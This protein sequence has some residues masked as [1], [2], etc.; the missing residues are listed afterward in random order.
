MATLDD[1]QQVIA[2][3]D[4]LAKDMTKADAIEFYGE[5]SSQFD[6]AATAMEE[7]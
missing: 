6:S 7:M 4:R 3:A 1:I 5:L 2:L